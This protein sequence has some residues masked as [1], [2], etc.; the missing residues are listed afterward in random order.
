MK[1]LRWVTCGIFYCRVSANLNGS[2]SLQTSP[3]LD[4][5]VLRNRQQKHTAVRYG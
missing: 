3:W 1:K 2:C 4:C 5:E